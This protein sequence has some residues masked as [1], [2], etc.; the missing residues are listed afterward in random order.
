MTS[1]KAKGS[2]S[3]KWASLLDPTPQEA[4]PEEEWDEP[5]V[6][7]HLGETDDV[8]TGAEG[9]LP[10][11]AD[12]SLTQGKYLGVPSSREKMGIPSQEDLSSE[13]EEMGSNPSEDEEG[14]SASGEASSSDDDLELE[15]DT[16]RKAFHSMVRP[17]QPLDRP[18]ISSIFST[19]PFFR[20]LT[21][22]PK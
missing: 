20:K 1:K 17:P 18:P 22:W 12:I 19:T 10:M 14:D 21:L 11:R 6:E 5:N 15:D 3:A 4:V 8:S 16:Y 9:R 2:L 7:T 13:D